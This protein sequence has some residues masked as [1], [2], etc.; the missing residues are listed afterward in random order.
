VW[1][2]RQGQGERIKV[3]EAE[4]TYVA[5]D[6]EGQPRELGGLAERPAAKRTRRSAGLR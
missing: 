2:L 4:F 6:E 1:V 5:V 3:T